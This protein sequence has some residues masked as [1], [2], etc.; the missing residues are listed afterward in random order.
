MTNENNTNIM[1]E[2]KV[3]NAEV[4]LTGKYPVN[5]LINSIEGKRVYI[6][7]LYAINKI[8]Q[9]IIEEQ[10]LLKQ[11]PNYVLMSAHKQ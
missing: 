2:Y 11:V 9:L 7:D 10:D 6:P 5:N 8:I 3:N 4:V 1:R